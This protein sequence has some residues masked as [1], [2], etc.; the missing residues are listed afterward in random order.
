MSTSKSVKKGLAPIYT[1]AISVYVIGVL[2]EWFGHVHLAIE[3]LAWIFSIT[4]VIFIWTLDIIWCLN[5]TK[6]LS[7]A[8]F[9]LFATVLGIIGVVI[10][11]LLK[12]S[13]SMWCT[14][15]VIC[16]V[17]IIFAI[18]LG[19]VCQIYNDISRH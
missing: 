2:G 13:I 4:A 9:H 3:I 8:V 15:S 17:G 16:V 6:Y 12:M 11:D 5:T 19:R 14:V 10:Y 1:L 18:C 7:G